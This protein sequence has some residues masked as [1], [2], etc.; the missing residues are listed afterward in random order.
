MTGLSLCLSQALSFSKQ[1]R[2]YN[3]S[4]CDTQHG[5]M[6]LRSY[7]RQLLEL[8]EEL[9]SNLDKGKQTDVIIV[10]IAKAVDRVNHSLLCHKLDHYGI[11]D[12]TN[13][14]ISSFLRERRQAVVVEGTQSEFIPV[15][16]GVPQG[17][18]LGPCLFL[19]V[20]Q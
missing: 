7:E 1:S 18:I 17:S 20:H 9:T 10:D 3:F 8:L 12:G 6:K 14:W 15:R 5:F 2:I 13:H 16:P 4:I 19:C 11:R